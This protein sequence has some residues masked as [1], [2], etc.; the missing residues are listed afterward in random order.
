MRILLADDDDVF[1]QRLAR[2][3]GER[4]HEVIQA[5]TGKEALALTLA[6][7][8]EAALLDLKMPE[9]NGL[10]ALRHMMLARPALAVVILTGY[11]S[12]PTAME[13]VRL[14]ALD[15]LIKPTDVDRILDVFLNLH[16]RG[17]AA[18]PVD[19]ALPSLEMVEWEY[20]QRVL[21]DCDHNISE[22]ARMLGLHRR[23]LQRKLQKY[24][25]PR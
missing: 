17:Q 24:P 3:L 21:V 22:A 19:M 9:M 25:P 4:G 12:I 11:G 10:E 14:G 16:D 1:R 13:A 20:I 18:T 7:A 6:G 5:A 2:A 8:P 23:S 15:Y